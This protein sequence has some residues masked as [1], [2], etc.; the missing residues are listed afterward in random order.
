MDGV[1]QEDQGEELKLR[2]YYGPAFSTLEFPDGRLPIDF[3]EHFTVANPDYK[4]E[5]ENPDD[6]TPMEFEFFDHENSVI[7]TGLVYA[8]VEWA[9]CRGLE[10][11]LIDFPFDL[12]RGDEVVEVPIDIVPGVMLR[13]YQIEAAQTCLSRWR[14]VVEIA[15]GGG[16][17][18]V[19]I[20]LVLVLKKPQTIFMCPDKLSLD[21]MYERFTLRGFKPFEEV[22]RYGDGHDDLDTEPA[23]LISTVQSLYSGL[24]RNDRRVVERLA[25]CELF[26]ADECHHKATAWSWKAVG[27]HC[28]AHRRIG[29]SATPYKTAK[30]RFNPSYLH[31]H[32][33]WLTGLI[34]DTI[35]YLP[36]VELQK[37]GD[38]AKCQVIGFEAARGTQSLTNK[39]HDVYEAG[40]V[41]NEGRN[42]QIATLAA[43]LADMGRKPLISVTRLE[44]GRIIQRMLLRGFGVYA[45]CSYGQGMTYVPKIVAEDTETPYEEIPVYERKLTKEELAKGKEPKLLG[46]E[47]EFVQIPSDVC[48]KALIKTGV[49]MVLIGSSVYDESQDIPDLT[50]LIN[51]AGGKAEQR[52]WQKVG[53]VL[54]LDGTNSIA[55]IWEPWDTNHYYLRNHSRKRLAALQQQGFPIYGDWSFARIFHDHRLRDYTVKEVSMKY[56]KLSVTTA[57]TIPLPRP[58][59]SNIKPA[60]TLSA[61]L[62]EGDDPLACSNRLAAITM[63]IFYQEAWREAQEQGAMLNAGAGYTGL[64]ARAQEYLNQFLAGG[65]SA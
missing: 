38:L 51:A 13:T 1:Q 58:E 27:K 37:S 57:M 8:A 20:A 17:T 39:W 52:L 49:V 19:A 28:G 61:T 11:E 62:E 43:N 47:P 24:K 41:N 50:D 25:S 12:W 7:H 45:A 29:L 33:S 65:E 42:R 22:G 26:I 55:W 2:I 6:P 15:T 40:V 54:R 30:S 31:G 9:R 32:D 60:V 48:V 34:G 59:Y 46:Y 63:A 3:G 4:P 44:H 64:F 18:E 53:R 21:G 10:V 5:Y 35:F 56:D 36:A 14:G 23:V 16:K